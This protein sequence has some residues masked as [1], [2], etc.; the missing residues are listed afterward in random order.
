MRQGARRGQT[1]TVPSDWVRVRRALCTRSA[2][3]P[4][5]W[6]P[7]GAQHGRRRGAARTQRASELIHVRDAP[8]RGAA[9]QGGAQFVLDRGG[10]RRRSVG[11]IHH[12]R[13]RDAVL[14]LRVSLQRRATAP[15]QAGRHGGVGGGESPESRLHCRRRRTPARCA[16]TSNTQRLTAQL[17]ATPHH[18]WDGLRAAPLIRFAGGMPRW[19]RSQSA[20]LRTSRAGQPPHHGDASRSYG[21]TQRTGDQGAGG[22]HLLQQQDACAAGAPCARGPPRA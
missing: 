20:A 21:R 8:G 13:R 18:T 19:H 2:W 7:R 14:I 10:G 16:A 9:L 4:Q 11:H 22:T 5:I 3:H 1:V 15:P 17:G 12:R 6:L